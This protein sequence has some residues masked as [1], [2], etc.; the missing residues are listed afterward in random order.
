[1]FN[2][3]ILTGRL[4]TDVEVKYT[5]NDVAVAAF[6]IAVERK[7]KQGSD[8]VTDFINLVAWRNTAEFI[9]KYFTKGS[10]IGI[11]GHIETRKYDDR[12]GNKRTVFEVIVE[13]AQF[14]SPKATSNEEFEEVEDDGDIP[15]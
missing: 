10:L 8:K 12:D 1:M 13:D 15:F 14:V 6:S 3:V 9:G 7:M 11:E 5:K 4:T 2:K